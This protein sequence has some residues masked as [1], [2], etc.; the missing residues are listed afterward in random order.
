[1][2]YL[3]ELFEQAAQRGRPDGR[4]IE[5]AH[6]VDVRRIVRMKSTGSRRVIER[7]KS[8]ATPSAFFSSIRKSTLRRCSQSGRPEKQQFR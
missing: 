1:M 7:D 3:P 6:Q 4:V 5:D 8:R 2:A